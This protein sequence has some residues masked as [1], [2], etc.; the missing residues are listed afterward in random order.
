M[1]ASFRFHHR[2]VHLHPFPSGNGRHAHIAADEFLKRYFDAPPIEWAG[3]FDLQLDDARP[4][5]YSK[6]LGRDAA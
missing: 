3:G 6:A 5:A 2:M 4:D 1:A